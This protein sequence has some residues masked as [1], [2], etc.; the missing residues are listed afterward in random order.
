MDGR[1]I[2]IFAP[3]A[4]RCTAENHLRNVFRT[5]E[6]SHGIRNASAFQAN[7]LRTKTF[8]KS[9]IGGEH[10][11]VRFFR[12]ELAIHMDNVKL[13]VHAARHAGA[14]CDQI[15]SRWIRRDAHG[16]TFPYRPV[17]PDV[18]GF[19]VGFEAAID[20][21]S[22]LTQGKFAQGN[23]IAAAKEILERAFDFVRTV[24]VPALH[25]VLQG[26][27]REID[28]H[29]F[30]CS[31]GHPIWD[32]F[33]H[34]DASDGAHNRSS[35][36]NVLDVEC[37]DNIDLCRQDFLD[38]LVAFAVFAAGNVR[39]CEFIHQDHG[40][41]ARQNGVH[42]HFFEHR[43]LVFDL[44]SGNSLNLRDE[45]FDAFAAMRLDDSDDHVFAA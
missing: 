13:R 3:V 1:E 39:V 5:N 19:H 6:L 2:Q 9:Q 38:V 41:A 26:F 24:D 20:L 25:A 11:L 12:A 7:Y 33:T 15:L 37:G 44:F 42:I 14:A 8:R 22:D 45:F 18:L 40:R 32:G 35:A 16:D 36:L 23:E 43:A 17:F 29:G 27:R 34:S 28:H 4:D 21:F 10:S 30:G 31:Q